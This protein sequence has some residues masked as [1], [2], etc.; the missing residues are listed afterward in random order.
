[1]R[2]HTTSISRW[3]EKYTVYSQGI[4]YLLQAPLHANMAGRVLK[5]STTIVGTVYNRTYLLRHGRR[6]DSTWQHTG[7]AVRRRGWETR[8]RK[9][10][11]DPS[12]YESYGYNGLVSPA[13]RGLPESFHYNTNF[14]LMITNW[15]CISSTSIPAVRRLTI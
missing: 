15:V 13:A 9:N 1:M 2:V 10:C 6:L 4:Q 14:S 3:H 8:A 7:T 11:A 5:L 12:I